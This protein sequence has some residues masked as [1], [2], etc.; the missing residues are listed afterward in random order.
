MTKRLAC[1]SGFHLSAAKKPVLLFLLSFTLSSVYLSVSL[2]AWFF[3]SYDDNHYLLQRCL[4]QRLLKRKT[5]IRRL[6][7]SYYYSLCFTPYNH[8]SYFSFFFFHISEPGTA[9]IVIFA[10]SLLILLI[11]YYY[12]ID[13]LLFF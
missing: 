7:D 1:S 8:F 9:W 3:R 11:Y 12:F 2:S 13:L 5:S 10:Y 6:I 4:L